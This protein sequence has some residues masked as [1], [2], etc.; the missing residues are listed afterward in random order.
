M[1]ARMVDA[2]ATGMAA[3][4]KDCRDLVDSHRD[5]P[6]DML[7]Q[8]GHWQL[9]IDAVRR[10]ESLSPEVKA[11]VMAALGWRVSTSRNLASR[12]RTKQWSAM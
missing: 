8:L 6:R 3:R 10:H 2:Q 11:D 4:I 7:V 5:W 9:I 1:A 12:R